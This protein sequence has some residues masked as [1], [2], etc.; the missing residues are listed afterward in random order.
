MVTLIQFRQLDFVALSCS[1]SIIMILKNNI[2]PATLSLWWK[3]LLLLN[4][5]LKWE[6][7]KWSEGQK[8]QT[9]IICPGRTQFRCHTSPVYETSFSSYI[10]TP[11]LGRVSL[12]TAVFGRNKWLD[13][14]YK[15]RLA[16][17][18]LLAD[19]LFGLLSWLKCYFLKVCC[20]SYSKHRKNS[21]FF[22]QI[23]YTTTLVNIPISN[24]LQW[25]DF[26]LCSCTVDII[27]STKS[28]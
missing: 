8:G 7:Y 21:F 14:S 5:M 19:G 28:F 15:G 18:T 25:C 23:N 24:I 3:W 12:Q 2:N 1:F 6:K 20:R 9:C 17:L 27:I 13:I 26:C 4:Y 22:L 11:E 16:C 10:E